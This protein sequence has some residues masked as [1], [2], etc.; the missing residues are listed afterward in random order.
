VKSSGQFVEV[1]FP[2][3]QRR[4]FT[5]EV[6]DDIDFDIYPGQRV[7][8][9]LRNNPTVGF[10][11][12]ANSTKPDGI[13]IKPIIEI[14][15]PTPIFPAELFSFLKILSNYYLTSPGKVLHTAIPAEYQL[16]KRRR[17]CITGSSENEIPE[18]YRPLYNKISKKGDVLLSSLKRYFDTP[19]INKGIALLKKRGLITEYPTFQKKRQTGTVQKI[20][21][22]S[23][24][25]SESEIEI[26]KLSKK[27]PRQWEIIDVLRNS[28]GVLKGKE[29]NRFSQS[30]LLSLVKKNLI[31]TSKVDTTIDDLW[32][33]YNIRQKDVTLN[34][35]QESAFNKIKGSILSEKFSS[36]LLQGLT[37]SGKTSHR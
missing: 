9:P 23:Q 17:I 26:N 4:H 13:K 36:F 10:I 27:A 16:Q 5:Y 3:P 11:I 8:A 24:K 7:V 37:G 34:S 33:E 14:I 32:K 35:D 1:V 21:R 28:Y 6:P 30:A 18:L 22:L 31:S 29:V 20:I 12:N 19:Y 15:D 2:I 25:F